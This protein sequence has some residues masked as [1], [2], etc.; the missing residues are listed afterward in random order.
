MKKNNTR[1][2]FEIW[3]DFNK[4]EALLKEKS[5]NQKILRLEN[6]VKLGDELE[7]IINENVDN[8]IL[9]SFYLNEGIISSFRKIKDKV[10]DFLS[11]GWMRDKLDDEGKRI[12]LNPA[13]SDEVALYE[14]EYTEKTKALI[15]LLVAAKIAMVAIGS[16]NFH[17]KLPG[18]NSG[19][20]SDNV[21]YKEKPLDSNTIKG[22]TFENPYDAKNINIVKSTIKNVAKDVGIG[23]PSDA[24]LDAAIKLTSKNLDDIVPVQKFKFKPLQI[25]VKK[26]AK[27]VEKNLGKKLPGESAKD[28]SKRISGEADSIKKV[29]DKWADDD[30]G[31]VEK[32]EALAH[33]VKT[34]DAEFDYASTK[35]TEKSDLTKANDYMEKIIDSTDFSKLKTTIDTDNVNINK[36]NLNLSIMS[37]AEKS[38]LFNAARIH[39]LKKLKQAKPKLFSKA[40]SY[41]TKIEFKSG[42]S[43]DKSG[44]ETSKIDKSSMKIEGNKESRILSVIYSTLDQFSFDNTDTVDGVETA[45]T[46]A[47]S[48]HNLSRDNPMVDNLYNDFLMFVIN[49]CDNNSVSD[50]VNSLDQPQFDAKLNTHISVLTSHH[51]DS[52]TSAVSGQK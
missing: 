25:N 52:K 48:T 8:Y 31:G 37:K 14:K 9:E 12:K 18:A 27:N 11:Q 24:D 50:I 30:P 28:L 5:K 23:E 17:V 51:I 2:I 33:G 32:G 3:R 10:K 6:L 45:L 1:E 36:V 16:A 21:G 42:G 7:Y 49:N 26:I 34:D 19:W 13:D 22:T 29:T 40:K 43:F 35:T 38:K 47:F 39:S 46:D 44:K 20:G 41:T 15:G 4:K